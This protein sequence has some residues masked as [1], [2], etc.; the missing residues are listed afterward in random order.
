MVM[1]AVPIFYSTLP[2]YNLFL[3]FLFKKLVQGQYCKTFYGRNLCITIVSLC[4]CHC[5][6]LPPMSTNRCRE[7]SI[8]YSGASFDC[9]YQTRL[10]AACSNYLCFG[11][12]YCNTMFVERLVRYSALFTFIFGWHVSAVSLPSGDIILAQLAYPMNDVIFC[13]HQEQLTYLSTYID[14]SI[15]Y[16]RKIFHNTDP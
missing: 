3:R 7:G 1:V 8:F 11:L 2:N 12:Q 6:T 10:E 13:L 9:K 16:D 5:Q 14:C 15:N 4:I